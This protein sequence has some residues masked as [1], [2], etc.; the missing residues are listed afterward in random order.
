MWACQQRSASMSLRSQPFDSLAVRW[1]SAWVGA[2]LGRTSRG[3]FNAILN[4][5]C[6]DT[7]C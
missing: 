6:M 3:C 2:R 7:L 5:P 4:T 1:A